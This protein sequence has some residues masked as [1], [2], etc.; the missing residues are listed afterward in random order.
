MN[1]NHA[2]KTIEEQIRMMQIRGLAFDD[3][4]AA[5]TKLGHVSYFRFACYLRH[6]ETDAAHNVIPGTKFEQ[7][8]NL[9][10]FDCA[11]SGLIFNA[12]KRMEISLRTK[13]IQHFSTAHG[14]HWYMDASLFKNASIHSECMK[15]LKRELSRSNEDFIAEYY[16]KYSAPDCPP[17]WKTLEVASF[18]TLSKLYCNF[19]DSAVKNAVARE[20]GIPHY[21]FLESWVKSAT[22]LRNCCAHHARVWNRRFAV[23]PMLPNTLPN[24]WL[25]IVPSPTRRNKIYSQLCYLAYL[26]H[27]VTNTHIFATDLRNLLAQYP[28]VDVVAMG[29]L[30]NWENEPLWAVLQG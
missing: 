4:A 24:D 30:R 18:G 8:T 10:D 19:K 25:N 6:F 26:S 14:S 9:Y 7:V 21:K 17:A 1:Y 3:I 23:M 20:L 11:L 22:V 29:F 16:A 28:D 12:I 5:K 15:S 13:V 27:A 2:A